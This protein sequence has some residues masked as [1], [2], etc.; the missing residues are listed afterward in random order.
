MDRAVSNTGF[1]APSLGAVQFDPIQNENAKGVTMGFGI[2]CGLAF[3]RSAFMWFPIHP[4]GYLLAP[5]W[6]GKYVWFICFLAWG[7]RSLTLKV[8]GAHTIRRGLV[9]FC[10]GMF[11]ACVS[12]VVLFDLIGIYLRTQGVTNVYCRWP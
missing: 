7:I 1:T 12:S 11:L 6:F 3:L 2:T 5:T 9:P 8:G 10:V 4:I